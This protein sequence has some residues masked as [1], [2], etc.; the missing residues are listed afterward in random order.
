MCI[1]A[2]YFI[3]NI[4]MYKTSYYVFIKTL[5]YKI[6]KIFSK[7]TSSH[8]RNT[9]WIKQARKDKNYFKIKTAD[10]NGL[11]SSYWACVARFQ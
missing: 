1:H 3:F 4:D 8:L 2:Y 7:L 6:I 10:N 11:I 5:S 9:Y